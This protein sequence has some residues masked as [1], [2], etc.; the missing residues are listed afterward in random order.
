MPGAR[1]PARHW[2]EPSVTTGRS[3]VA[4]GPGVGLPTLQGVALVAEAVVACWAALVAFVRDVHQPQYNLT[5]QQWTSAQRVKDSIP[6][7]APTT[8]DEILA[9]ALCVMF[10]EVDPPDLDQDKWQ[11]AERLLAGYTELVKEQR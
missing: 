5:E 2:S 1:M 9:V 8:E 10:D 4:P 3:G 11:A 6:Y 7:P